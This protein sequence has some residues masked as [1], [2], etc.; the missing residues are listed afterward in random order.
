[1]QKEQM[2]ENRIKKLASEEERLNKQIKA[3]NKH[4]NFADKVL[5]R[6]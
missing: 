1:M 2:M 6:R 3:A 5:Q 4:A